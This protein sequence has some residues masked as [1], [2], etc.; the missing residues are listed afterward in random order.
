MYNVILP[1][2]YVL[3]FYIN[4]F[5]SM[6]AVPSTGL[7]L[8]LLF[9]FGGGGSYL[10]SCFPDTLL[11]YCLSDFDLVLVAH[12]ITDVTVVVTFHMH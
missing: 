10:I 7:L 4:T 2:K 6:C 5:H 12:I 8:L 1:V 9:F 11:R 3:C